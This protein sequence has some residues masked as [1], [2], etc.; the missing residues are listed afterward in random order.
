MK[1]KPAQFTSIHSIHKT[2]HAI[3][4]SARQLN[5]FCPFG[6]SEKLTDPH[7]GIYYNLLESG[8][9]PVAI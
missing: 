6:Y 8:G 2:I 4:V 1:A 9:L 5:G 7:T 3:Q